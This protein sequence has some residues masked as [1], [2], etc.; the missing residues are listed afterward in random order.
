MIQAFVLT[1]VTEHITQ[2]AGIIGTQTLISF[3]CYRDR[4]LDAGYSW[5]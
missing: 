4:E 5:T 3:C 2:L 1:A